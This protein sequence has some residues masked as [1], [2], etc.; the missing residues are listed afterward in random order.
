MC[1]RVISR[2][3]FYVIINLIESSSSIF[4]PKLFFSCHKQDKQ[5]TTTFLFVLVLAL[6]TWVLL[7]LYSLNTKNLP[8]KT[9]VTWLKVLQKLDILFALLVNET[10]RGDEVPPPPY[11]HAMF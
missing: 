11:N 7:F 5:T 8:R 10:G 9:E 6:S 4:C 2:A 1:K 3:P